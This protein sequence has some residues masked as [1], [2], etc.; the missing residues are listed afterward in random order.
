[1][2]KV[3]QRIVDIGHGDCMQSSIASMFDEEYEN[4]PPFVE[5]GTEWW[6]KFEEYFAS[7]GYK[8]KTVLYNPIMWDKTHKDSSLDRLKEF[9]GV[10]GLFYATVCSPKYN[11]NGELSGILHAVVVDK[12]FN[13]VHDPNP[14]NINIK[15]PHYEDIYHG[16]RT[17]EVFEPIEN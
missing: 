9:N 2:K 11:T 5:L 13:I 12:D 14:M 16:I 1:M 17:V 7:K 10:N 6:E 4:V 15:Y 3:Y 8:W